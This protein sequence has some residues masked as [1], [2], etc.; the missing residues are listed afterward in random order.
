MRAPHGEIRK[1]METLPHEDPGQ[2]V[3]MGLLAQLPF[4]LEMR[5]HEPAR[6]TGG[7]RLEHAVAAN[8]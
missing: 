6:N 5:M 7:S 4:E 3:G 1:L 8:I 2:V